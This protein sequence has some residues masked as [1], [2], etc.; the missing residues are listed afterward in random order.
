M[1]PEDYP[2]HDYTECRGLDTPAI[3]ENLNAS[4]HT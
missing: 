3:G 4:M 1:R 2:N